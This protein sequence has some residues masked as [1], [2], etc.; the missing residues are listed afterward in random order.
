ML[1]KLWLLIQTR[2]QRRNA[3]R[4]MDD[5]LRFHLEM[6]IEKRIE[7]GMK[8]QQARREALLQFGGIQ[9]VKEGYPD[10]RVQAG[11]TDPMLPLGVK[12][13]LHCSA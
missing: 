6:Q 10:A 5:E 1:R 3:E 12:P 8:P 9:Q 7:R 2:L 13:G 11:C 4:E